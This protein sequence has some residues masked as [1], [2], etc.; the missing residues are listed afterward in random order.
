MSQGK[1][2]KLTDILVTVVIAIAFGV[3][4]KLWGTIYRL[5]EPFGLQ[6]NEAIYG[7]WFIA[8]VVAFLVVRKPGVALIAE[9]V[10]AHGEFLLGADWGMWILVY[11]FFQGLA[12][13]LVFA[14]F[15]YQK[16]NLFVVGLA[17]FAAA[18][19]SFAVDVYY[20][21][22]LDLALWNMILKYTVRGISG[23]VIAGI[24]AYYIVKAL[25]KTGVT[26]LVRPASKEDYDA[27]EN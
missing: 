7:M 25:E 14:A 22:T 8:A 1:G 23:I 13:E 4:Y 18:I 6:L 20:G 12:C 10:A 26:N 27:L 11:G 15:R 21:Y 16:F 3:I 5:V 2:L 9:L 19:G 24:F 17:G